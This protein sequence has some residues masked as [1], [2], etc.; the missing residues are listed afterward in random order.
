MKKLKLFLVYVES[1]LHDFFLITK[2]IIAVMRI[3]ALKKLKSLQFELH[4]FKKFGEV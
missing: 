3:F 1:R 4:S 2:I